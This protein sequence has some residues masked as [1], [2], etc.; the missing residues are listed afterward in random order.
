MRRFIA[1]FLIVLLLAPGCALAELQRGDRGEEVTEL[2]QMLFDAGFLFE[3]PDGVFGRN[4]ED[5]VKWFQEYVQ[6]E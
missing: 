3:L 1:L 6:L 2:Q 4:T 5:A